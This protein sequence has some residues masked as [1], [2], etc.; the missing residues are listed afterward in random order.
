MREGSGLNPGTIGLATILLFFYVVDRMEMWGEVDKLL[1][2]K[3][4]ILYAFVHRSDGMLCI[5]LTGQE[6]TSRGYLP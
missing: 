5:Y 1:P 4:A 3:I 2:A 6:L